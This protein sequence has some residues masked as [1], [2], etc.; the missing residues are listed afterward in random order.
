M[1]GIFRN[2]RCDCWILV[3]VPMIPRCHD[4]DDDENDDYSVE[5]ECSRWRH[6][7]SLVPS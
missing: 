2:K 4:D 3:M 1:M 5:W 7:S 6:E